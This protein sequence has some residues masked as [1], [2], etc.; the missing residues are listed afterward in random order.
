MLV[1]EREMGISD[2]H[3]GIIEVEDKY[4]VGESI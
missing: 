1:S 2:E 3:D 4:K